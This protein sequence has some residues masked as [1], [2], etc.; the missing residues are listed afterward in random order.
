MWF[1]TEDDKKKN[2]ENSKK[3]TFH[4]KWEKPIIWEEWKWVLDDKKKK[5]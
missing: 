3:V 4:I 1:F 5:K 2:E